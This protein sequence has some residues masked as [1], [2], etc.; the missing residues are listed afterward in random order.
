MLEQSR[1]L[2]LNLG[3]ALLENLLQGLGVLQLLLDLGNNRLGKLLLLALLDLTL[4]TNPRV[5]NGL[6]LS[7]KGGLLLELVSLSLK[8]GSLL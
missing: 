2:T 3:H 7:G 1:G 5:E 4:I 6:G 8:L